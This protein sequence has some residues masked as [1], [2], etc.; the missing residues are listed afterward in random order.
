M[1]LGWLCERGR[2]LAVYPC[3][4]RVRWPGGVAQ[5][6]W[7]GAILQSTPAPCQYHSLL[8][9]KNHEPQIARIS[10]MQPDCRFK[11]RK[12]GQLFIG[13]HTEA[14]SVPSVRVRNPDCSPPT[15]KG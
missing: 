13:V 3:G 1:F 7:R 2:S 12:R 10:P 11:F 8:K 4:K 15:I 9:R 6:T 14:F 5:R